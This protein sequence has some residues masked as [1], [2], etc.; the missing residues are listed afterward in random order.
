MFFTP[1][2]VE[3]TS[4]FTS[5]SGN[6]GRDRIMLR[7]SAYAHARSMTSFNARLEMLS[8]QSDR[9]ESIDPSIPPLMSR[10][11]S[12][13]LMLLKSIEIEDSNIASYTSVVSNAS[14]PLLKAIEPLAQCFPFVTFLLPPTSVVL[15]AL[16][17]PVSNI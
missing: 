7:L 2:S 1:M 17:H 9:A 13:M 4:I 3:Y 6:S 8:S 16:T 14:D 15:F 12:V 11:G 5:Q 10:A